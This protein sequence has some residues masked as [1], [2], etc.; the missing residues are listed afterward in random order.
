M[1]HPKFLLHD[2]VGGALWDAGIP[3]AEV[4]LGRLIPNLDPTS[5]SLSGSWASLIPVELFRRQR[6][7]NCT[8]G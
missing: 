7:D 8:P 5:C 3:V 6:R 4:Y 1:H 2:V